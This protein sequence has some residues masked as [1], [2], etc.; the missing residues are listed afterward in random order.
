MYLTT[1]YA[2]DEF[3][4]LGIGSSLKRRNVPTK[5][6]F[7]SWFFLKRYFASYRDATGTGSFNH[8]L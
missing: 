5:Q 2:L 7:S 1:F 4:K 3:V 6:G 8:P